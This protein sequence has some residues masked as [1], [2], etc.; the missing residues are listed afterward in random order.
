[1]PRLR[2]GDQPA[3][4]RGGA[5]V[6]PVGESEDAASSAAVPVAMP[7]PACVPAVLAQSCTAAMTAESPP[8]DA[9]RVGPGGRIVL[10]GVELAPFVTREC[11]DLLYNCSRNAP[12][13]AE[14][15]AWRLMIEQTFSS[16]F[17]QS[18]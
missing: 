18:V 15:S 5:V 17:S 6:N 16:E 12:S 10:Y 2:P 7:T 3:G 1:M 8:A 14:S 13:R 9:P 4:P 11:A